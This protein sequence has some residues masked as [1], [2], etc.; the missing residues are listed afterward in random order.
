LEELPFALL[1]NERRKMDWYERVM[2]NFEKQSTKCKTA[3]YGEEDG[4]R[5]LL[6]YSMLC[7]LAAE[8]SGGD[9]R[10]ELLKN[11]FSVLLP[12]VSSDVRFWLPV[13]NLS[14]HPETCLSLDAILH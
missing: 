3:F 2:R 1:L 7:L 8:Q 6:S 12:M 13:S 5:A 4:I 9:E 10:D 14:V 11:S